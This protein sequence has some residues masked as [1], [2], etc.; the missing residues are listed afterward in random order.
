MLLLIFLINKSGYSL[1]RLFAADGEAGPVVEV[2]NSVRSVAAHYTVASVDK[3]SRKMGELRGVS[4]QSLHIKFRMQ[5]LSVNLLVAEFREIP[6]GRVA[7]K[8]E[9]GSRHA[10]ATCAFTTRLLIPLFRNSPIIRAFS[11]SSAANLTSPFSCAASSPRFIH[12]PELPC[13][14]AAGI[15]WLLIRE[16]MW[17][18]E[19]RATAVALFITAA[20]LPASARIFRVSFPLAI[21]RIRWASSIKPLFAGSS[22]SGI[23]VLQPTRAAVA[24]RG[25]RQLFSFQPL[26]SPQKSLRLINIFLVVDVENLGEFVSLQL[27]TVFHESPLE[28]SHPAFA[29]LHAFS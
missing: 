20:W 14:G 16:S 9:F 24:Q 2:D 19:L 5:R 15:L 18:R 6:V 27:Q 10:I 17:L 12:H 28:V 25:R 23:K 26:F 3:N 22:S 8:E 21:E 11:L 4:M 7:G 13:S 29:S 1:S